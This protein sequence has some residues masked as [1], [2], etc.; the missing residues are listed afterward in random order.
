M[1]DGTTTRVCGECGGEYVTSGQGRFL[2]CSQTCKDSARSK[3]RAARTQGGAECSTP[4][5][6]RP[7]DLNRPGFPVCNACYVAQRR[8]STGPCAAKG[9]TANSVT[10]RPVPLCGAHKWRLDNGTP[11]AQLGDRPLRGSDP[12]TCSRPGCAIPA[13]SAWSDICRPHK[14]RARTVAKYG[15]TLDEYDRMVE[16]QGGRCAVCATDHPGGTKPGQKLPPAWHIDHDHDHGC[17]G[18]ACPECV[19]ALLCQNCNLALG[20]LQDDPSRIEALAAYARHHGTRLR[21]AS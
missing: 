19:R 18:H 21:A 20:Y 10:S 13:G 4:G 7:R 12:G 2:Y 16:A 3:R 15:L 14:E 8:S 11:L 5:C 6:T 1:S 9:C 17:E